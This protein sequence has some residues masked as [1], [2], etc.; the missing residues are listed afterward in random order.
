MDTDTSSL[1]YHVPADLP[2]FEVTPPRIPPPKHRHAAPC[3]PWPWMD[4]QSDFFKPGLESP[5]PSRQQ[6]NWE[7]YPQNCFP[8]W[9][10]SQARRSR[11]TTGCSGNTESTIYKVDVTQTGLFEGYS[12]HRCHRG[13]E[14]SF[15]ESIQ[16]ERPM[17][18]RLRTLFVHNMS[19]PVLQMLGTKYN[20][21]P[22]FFSSS[23]N[24]IPSRYQEWDPPGEADHITI[25][26]T[27]IR[28]RTTQTDGKPS[29]HSR[30]KVQAR[31]RS[32]FLAEDEALIDTQ[33][34]LFLTSKT[35]V[36]HLQFDLLALHLI[37]KPGL[38]TIIS[39]HPDEKWQTTSADRLRSLVCGAS[40]SVYWQKIFEQ[41][42]DPTFVLLA[43]LWYA[44]YA[45]DEALS[46][47]YEH[48]TSLE[49]RVI[50][51][52]DMQVVR[53]LHK[54][55]A[56]LLHYESLLI[57]FK[58]SVTFV[59]ET[60]NPTM[61]GGP[62]EE[63]PFKQRAK[64]SKHLMRRECN[65]LLSEIERLESSR[66]RQVLR[67]KNVTDLAF[68][69]VNIE[70]T[71]AMK[72]IS[73]LTMF[74]LPATFVAG[75]F[76][77]N[78]IQLNSAEGVRGTLGHYAVATVALTL[79]TI[80][81]IVALERSNFVHGRGREKSIWIRLWWP[82]LYLSRRLSQGDDHTKGP[83]I[84]ADPCFSNA[85]NSDVD[86]KGVELSSTTQLATFRAS[87]G[88]TSSRATITSSIA[89]PRTGEEVP[90][91]RQGTIEQSYLMTPPLAAAV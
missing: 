62:F 59:L 91:H 13:Q 37:R 41:S 61:E 85:S 26:L 82:I 1:P 87:I 20:V 77:M 5:A 74:F 73:Y 33:T 51:T 79:F 56:H 69:T 18:I 70:D 22:F 15:W 78:V 48:I 29:S 68:A 8:N 75:I 40:Q 72:Q 52:N 14:E 12:D 6:T 3:G 65:H 80:W 9:T 71:A 27:F 60:P 55:R 64:Y 11:I 86:D 90:G 66:N 31:S 23:L 50:S 46:V 36:S 7:T 4:L 84:G 54:I 2:G 67:L 21:E 32:L 17:D 63:E 35:G 16:Q 76:G 45:W 44:V 83:Q 42:D 57:D 81:I 10:P 47:L 58:K 89:R 43:I 34:P 39:Y 30:S 88:T 24:W 49:S 38:N 53:E 19:L 25:T 28:T